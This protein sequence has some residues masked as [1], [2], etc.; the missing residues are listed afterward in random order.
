MPPPSRHLRNVILA[1]M[2]AMLGCSS[3]GSGDGLPLGGVLPGMGAI[4][5]QMT[6]LRD[7]TFVNVVRQHTDFSCGAAALATILRYG[8][9]M[10]VD[11]KEVFTGM[12]EVSDK[13]TVRQRGFSMF[14]MKKYLET[15]GMQGAGF[16]IAPSALYQVKVPVIVLLNMGGYEHFVVMRK[17]TPN[18]VFVADPALGN[19]QMPNDLF[20]KDWQRSVIFAV[21]GPKYIPENVLV[22]TEKPLSPNQETRNLIPAFNPLSEV[23]LA[24]LTVIPGLNLGSK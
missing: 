1:L 22:T 16:Q 15:I 18:G 24:S 5:P 23:T 11:E 10:N 8:Y 7:Q 4:Y 6:T 2:A 21:I 14:D 13:A 12:Y 3:A 19:R 20:Y 17:A 9:G